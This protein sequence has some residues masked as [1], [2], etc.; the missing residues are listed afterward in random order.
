MRGPRKN[1][2]HAYHRARAGELHTTEERYFETIAAAGERCTRVHVYKCTCAMMERGELLQGESVD[3]R[4]RSEEK[5]HRHETLVAAEVVDGAPEEHEQQTCRV[6]EPT[7]DLEEEQL[8]SVKITAGTSLV[9]ENGDTQARGGAE[10]G[11]RRQFEEEL[12][13]QLALKEREIDSVLKIQLAESEMKWAA[14]LEAVEASRQEQAAEFTAEIEQLKLQ[15]SEE[16]KSVLMACRQAREELEALKKQQVKEVQHM[17]A[18]SE[19]VH[20]AEI[21]VLRDELDKLRAERDKQE[22]RGNEKWESLLPQHSPHLSPQMQKELRLLKERLQRQHN[23]ELKA[24]ERTLRN[25]LSL[26]IDALQAK[27]EEEYTGKLAKVLTES[28]LKN[29]LQVEQIS[30][31][32]RLEKQRAVSV[33]EEAQTAMHEQEVA[34]LLEER[35]EAVETCRTELESARIE[36]QSKIA[37]LEVALA[38]EREKRMATLTEQYQEDWLEREER[39]R[40]EMEIEYR[41]RVE[42][43]QAE[44]DRE[45]ENALMSLREALEERLQTELRAAHEIHEQA[46]RENQTQLQST[47]MY[48][49]EVA[50]MRES[51][52]TM[53]IQPQEDGQHE[54]AHVETLRAQIVKEHMARFQ[55]M[56]EKLQAVHQAELVAMQRERE[57]ESCRHQEEVGCVREMMETRI[58]QE[59]EQVSEILQGL[60]R[61][62]YVHV[63]VHVRNVYMYI[64]MYNY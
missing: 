18:E 19:R 44:C 24:Q 10:L 15:C 2:A 1:R 60:R 3:E 54:D 55:G 26:E 22:E 64:A 8:R 16:V 35:R 11:G 25:E 58:H 17:L 46:L 45:K 27:V 28:A 40:R 30:Q 39:L 5:Q 37:D 21:Q 29:A 9:K 51:A 7:R 50:A 36:Y 63:H 47:Y 34:R 52:H 43:A 4:E 6:R 41:R 42:E 59:L 61:E 38:S 31:Q 13:R 14:Q 33:L 53:P 12:Q 62:L 23:C 48:E 56:I 32:L 20:N 49:K 57:A